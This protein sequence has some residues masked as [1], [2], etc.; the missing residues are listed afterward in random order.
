MSA[1]MIGGALRRSALL[2]RASKVVLLKDRKL[3][4]NASP[5]TL[6]AT[7]P[8][9]RPQA[10]FMWVSALSLRQVYALAIRPFECAEWGGFAEKSEAA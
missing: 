4:E 1:E 7:E 6:N 5:A 3:P 8:I 10:P 9:V 2:N